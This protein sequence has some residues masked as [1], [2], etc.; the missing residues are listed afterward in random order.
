MGRGPETD[1]I[2]GRQDRAKPR[3]LI[4]PVG[5]SGERHEVPKVENKRGDD[6]RGGNPLSRALG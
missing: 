6:N 1:R 3:F 5:A 2:A 4:N